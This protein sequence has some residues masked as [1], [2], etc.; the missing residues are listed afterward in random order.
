MDENF[1]KLKYN[2]VTPVRGSVLISEP[3]SG[4]VYFS[5]SVVLL[6]QHDSLGTV[7]L[8][9]NKPFVKTL[10]EITDFFKNFDASINLGGPVGIHNIY[11]LHTLGDKISG[12]IHVKDNLFFGGNFADLKQLAF[13]GLLDERE[14]K[15]FLGYSGWEL[16][17][18]D[19]EIK[20]DYW[21]VSEVEVAE[22]MLQSEDIWQS[23]LS[24]MGDKYRFWANFPKNPDEN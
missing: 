9:L 22:I 16:G 8:I 4:D 13:L 15:F 1:F 23:V 19:A 10:S 21:L 17:Q 18:L 7:G 3:Y 11:F 12:S 2:K 20:K 24:R 6:I 14:V 5:R